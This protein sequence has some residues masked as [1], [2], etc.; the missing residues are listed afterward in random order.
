MSNPTKALIQRY[1]SSFNAGDMGGMLAL[2][3]DDMRHDVNQGPSRFGKTAFAEFCVHMAKCYRERLD[4]IVIMVSEDGTRAAAEFLV[5]GEY[6]ATDE[7]LPPAKGQ[8][9]T[10]PAGAFFEVAGGLIRRVTTFY[11]LPEWTRQVSR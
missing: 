1:Y 8:R 9:Y 4:H 7:G 3:S 5:H 10:L 6:L 11:N 2:L